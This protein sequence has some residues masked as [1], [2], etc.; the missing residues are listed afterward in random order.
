MVVNDVQEAIDEC[1]IKLYADDTVL[2][3]SGI[4]CEE[5]ANK[6]QRSIT[7][8]A[9]WCEEN[10]LTINVAKTKIMTFGTRHKV[11]KAKNVIIKLGNE[12][13]QHVPSYKYLGMILDSTLNYNLHVNQ[14]IRTVLHKLMLLSKMKK[15]LRD[16]TAICIYKSMLLP[17]LDYADVI[18]DRALNKDIS[19]LQKVQNKC[20]KVCMGKE[21]RFSNEIVHKLA[22]VPFLEDRREAHVLNFMYIRKS[23]VQLLNNRE[24]RT[25][26]H[27]APLFD[28]RVPR[29]EAYR[30]SVG[31]FGATKWNN[32]PPVIRNTATYL[33]F[34]KL[35][36]ERMLRPLSLIQIN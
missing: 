16:D 35:Q 28:T 21:R 33:A 25:M 20:L 8:F 32:L 6:L 26:A 24:I 27:D 23:R 14:V 12:R 17:Y 30:R 18:F 3:Q 4:N 1:G 5:A 11:K 2:Y 7:R 22:S 19:K 13:I 34:K 15:Y 31:Y 10:S 36:K 29:C 9:S